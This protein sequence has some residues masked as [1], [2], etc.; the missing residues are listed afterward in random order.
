[1]KWLIARFKFL[2]SVRI[3]TK[4]FWWKDGIKGPYINDAFKYFHLQLS[5]LHLRITFTFDNIFIYIF[6]TCKGHFIADIT[7][8]WTVVWIRKQSLTHPDLNLG[9]GRQTPQSAWLPVSCSCSVLQQ[10][11]SFSCPLASLPQSGPEA[12]WTEE[13]DPVFPAFFFI[14]H[15]QPQKCVFTAHL[16]PENL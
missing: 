3:P 10:R 6:C 12:K 1:M 11:R 8:L 5:F 16:S 4:L 13:T 14:L 7:N 9:P 15:K 2:E